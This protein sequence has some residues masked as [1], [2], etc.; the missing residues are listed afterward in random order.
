MSLRHL[1]VATASVLCLLSSVSAQ[2]PPKPQNADSGLALEV[3]FLRDTA[4]AYQMVTRTEA[5]KGGT[6]YARFGRVAGWR[7]PP[8]QKPIGAVRVVP[9]LEDDKVRV[10]VS[11]L[12]GKFLEV[13][14]TV[15]TYH[16]REN[17]KLTV[18]E[19]QDFGIQPFEIKVVRVGQQVTEIGPT[20]NR[21]RSLQLVG[22]EP[23]VE[24]FPCY[25]LTLNNQ[26]DKNVGALSITVMDGGK[27][28]LS[29]MPQG[30]KGEPLIKAND[31]Y[32][33]KQYLSFKVQAAPRDYTPASSSPQ[34]VIETLIYEDGTYEG[35][36]QPAALY[37]GFTAGRK[38]ELKRIVP[39]LE[40][41]LATSASLEELRLQLTRLSYNVDDADVSALVQ[42]FPKLDRMRLKSPIDTAIHG[43]RKELLDDLDRF[44][45]DQYR[46]GTPLEW[47]TRT[48]DVYSGW[49]SRLSA[50]KIAQP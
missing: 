1:I 5:P 27:R 21:T 26:S 30:K 34:I 4:P 32:E 8:G 43:V 44:Q 38:T 23:M 45:K 2:E 16:C 35:D 22:I 3:T 17:G 41:A 12:R 18:P 50:H 24:T 13:E 48:R 20:I 11:L 7:L 42:G 33:L 6:W 47:L 25:K 37:L 10:V 14:E 39:V 19:L 28:G 29:T 40:S 46:T 9:Y 49:L 31:S 15:A 36:S